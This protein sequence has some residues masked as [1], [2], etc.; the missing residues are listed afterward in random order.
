[1]RNMSFSITTRQFI[2]RTKWVSRRNGWI[3]LKPRDLVCGV[4]KA[5]GLKKG[6]KINRLG[7][8]RILSARR[9]ALNR[10]DQAACILEGFPEMSPT[11][12]IGNPDQIVTRIEFEYV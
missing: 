3:F 10:I 9:E 8:I 2:E 6:Q 1:M 5:M 11:Y 7:I 4:E 12:F